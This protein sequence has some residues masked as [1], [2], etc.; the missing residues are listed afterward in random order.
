MGL[1]GIMLR[2]INWMRKKNDLTHMGILKN[3]QQNKTKINP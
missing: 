1:K 3:K 2:K